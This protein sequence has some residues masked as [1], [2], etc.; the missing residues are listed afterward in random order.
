MIASASAQNWNTWR[1]RVGAVTLRSLITQVFL[2]ATLFG[3]P[4][5]AR[6]APEVETHAETS[7]ALMQSACDRTCSSRLRSRTVSL[8]VDRSDVLVRTVRSHRGHALR[9]A[10]PRWLRSDLP[11]PLLC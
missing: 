7:V 9:S 1:G 6:Q 3:G 10:P 4:G 2:L 5:L 8:C 11:G